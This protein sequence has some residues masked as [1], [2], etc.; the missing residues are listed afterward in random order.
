MGVLINGH[1]TSDPLASGN[2]LYTKTPNGI[3]YAVLFDSYS[4]AYARDASHVSC[5]IRCRWSDRLNFRKEMLGYSVWRSGAT[6]LDRYLAVACPVDTTLRCES[7]EMKKKGCDPQRTSLADSVTGWL[8]CDWAVYHAVFRKPPY[9]VCDDDATIP[10]GNTGR[11]EYTRYTSLKRQFS[12]RER[13]IPGLQFTTVETTVQVIPDPAFIPD[14]TQQFWLTWYQVPAESVPDARIGSCINTVNSVDWPIPIGNFGQSGNPGGGIT[15]VTIKYFTAT[16]ESLLFR[17][18]AQPVEPYPGAD[19][20]LYFDLTF[21]FDYRPT[22]YGWN[23]FRKND[24]TYV[25]L[26]VKGTGSSGTDPGTAPYP[27]TDHRLMFQPGN[28]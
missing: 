18:L 15:A 28:P 6:Y 4:E 19:G 22:T 2:W 8:E 17:G 20:N 16:A 5:L 25:R 23:G 27:K 21:C 12:G 11:F 13:R 24:G 26:K 10:F 3:A 14:V 9:L 1:L 7:L